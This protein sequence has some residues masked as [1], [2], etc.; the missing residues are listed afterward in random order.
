MWTVS[1]V[2]MYVYYY[3]CTYYMFEYSDIEI[4]FVIS[5]EIQSTYGLYYMNVLL[6]SMG[7]P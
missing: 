5:S 4:Y 3:L 7:W 6:Q 1:Y 2:C